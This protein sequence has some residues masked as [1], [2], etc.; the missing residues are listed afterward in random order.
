MKD[1]KF[2]AP[3]HSGLQVQRPV[4]GSQSILLSGLQSQTC[5]QL[6]PKNPFSHRVSQCKP[7]NPAAQVQEPVRFRKKPRFF[8]ACAINRFLRLNIFMQLDSSGAKKEFSK[9]PHNMFR[10]IS[11]FAKINKLHTR[12]KNDLI[13]IV[14]IKN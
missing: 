13:E 6:C 7:V 11:R 5:E 2:Y 9:F 4:A 10:K 8:C 14:R 12:K 3:R 1:R